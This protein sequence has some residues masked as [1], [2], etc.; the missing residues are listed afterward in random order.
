MKIL[1]P[2]NTFGAIIMLILMILVV[3]VPFT[4]SLWLTSMFAPWWVALPVSLLITLIVFVVVV[5]FKD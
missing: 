4:V 5:K 2:N 1:L 3:F